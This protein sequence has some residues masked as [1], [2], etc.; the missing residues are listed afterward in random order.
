MRNIIF[1]TTLAA[2]LIMSLAIKADP[3]T[4]KAC[5]DSNSD[6]P[7]KV[8]ICDM[9]QVQAAIDARNKELDEKYKQAKADLQ[10]EQDELKKKQSTQQPPSTGGSS[11]TDTASTS[12]SSKNSNGSNSSFSEPTPNNHS[13]SEAS[14]TS[15][16]A[17]NQPEPE[18]Q[19]PKQSGF[20][21]KPATTIQWY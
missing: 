7:D 9:Q 11:S 17:S 21:K 18:K 20:G 4:L 15:S 19:K 12:E 16:G 2:G 3:D 1:S 14:G 10:K 6:K 8:T 13:E 5:L